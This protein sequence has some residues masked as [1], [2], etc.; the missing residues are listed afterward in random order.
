VYRTVLAEVDQDIGRDDLDVW[1]GL[2]DW[3][4]PERGCGRL[5]RGLLGVGSWLI[6]IVVDRLDEA[7]NKAELMIFFDADDVDEAI[8]ELDRLHEQITHG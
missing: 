8:A 4:R 2:R 5:G 6:A 3:A 7:M 1:V